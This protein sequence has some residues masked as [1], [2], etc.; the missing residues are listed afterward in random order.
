MRIAYI[1]NS[2]IPSRSASSVHVMKMCQAL[3]RNGHEVTLIAIR[4]SGDLDSEDSPHAFYGV[5]ESFDLKRIPFGRHRGRGW[6]Y[7]WKSVRAAAARQP[8]VIYSRHLVA[9]TMACLRGHRT[10]LELHGLRVARSFE[11]RLMFRAL[12]RASTLER[13]VVISEALRADVSTAVGFARSQVIV[14]HDGADE[15]GDLDRPRALPNASTSTSIRMQVAY[16]G[17]LYAGRGTELIRE[18]ARR[19]PDVDFHLVGG[20]AEDIERMGQSAPANVHV[21]GFMP[22]RDAEAF[23]VHCDVLIAPYESTVMTAGGR[24][25]T[26][27]WMS[28]LKIF[29]Y[30]ASGKAIVCSDLPVLRE[31][32][33]HE[34]T[35]LLVAP[36]DVAAWAGALGRLVGDAGLRRRLGAAALRELRE[37]YTW[38]KRAQAV[39]EG[40]SAR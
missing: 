6:R 14:A 35:A 34:D 9:S 13:V 11:D 40:I 8:D 12:R 4:E 5:E 23:R 37:R 38:Q 26:S 32:L 25:D 17:H 21:H 7:A 16:V 19:L 29:E 18:V 28:P 20:H 36:D 31:V 1:A 39:L 15:V 27:R 30:M 10:V 2:A 22:H 33:T 24:T 3:A